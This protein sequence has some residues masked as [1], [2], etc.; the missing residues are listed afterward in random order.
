MNITPPPPSEHFFRITLWCLMGPLIWAVHFGV[1][2]GTQHLA[3]ALSDS[4][5]IIW[6][7]IGIILLTLICIAVLLIPIIKPQL[8]EVLDTPSTLAPHTKKT[9]SYIARCLCVLALF[10]VSAAGLATI[11]L[12]EC[13]Q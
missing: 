10:G 8:L 11:F 2:Y 5:N 9:L 6:L 13:G 4:E 3:C 1:L 12:R 7:K